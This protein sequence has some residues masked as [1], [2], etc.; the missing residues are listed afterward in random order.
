MVQVSKTPG[1]N[2]DKEMLTMA[3]EELTRLQRQ[4]K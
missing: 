4:V 1:L 2:T 3:E